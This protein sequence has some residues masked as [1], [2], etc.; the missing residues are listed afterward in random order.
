MRRLSLALVVA[1]ASVARADEPPRA[2]VTASKTEVGVGETFTVEVKGFGPAGTVWTFPEQAGNDDVE[3]RTPPAPPG[4]S[5]EALPPGVHRYLAAAFKLDEPEIPP[6]TVKYRLP[7]GTGGEVSTTPVKLRIVSVLPKDPGQQQLADIRAPLALSVGLAFWA[8]LAVVVLLLGG[9]VWWW[10]RRRR[11]RQAPAA[12]V[13]PEIPPDDE[14][15]AALEALAASG[16]LERGQHRPFYIALAEIAKRYLERRL[17]APIL[18]MTSSETVAFLREHA[19]LHDLAFATRDLTNAADQVKFARG[20]G[21]AEEAQRHLAMVRQLIETVETR[22]FPA[23]A[24][25]VA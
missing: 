22:L 9:L 7:D 10:V 23:P 18:E 4:A 17:H 13:V 3:L 21:A 5:P 6:V 19:Q 25:N 8:A 1:L 20:A 14:A 24:E 2:L 16:L 11:R 12:P 15:R